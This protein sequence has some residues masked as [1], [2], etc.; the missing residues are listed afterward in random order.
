MKDEQV[1]TPEQERRIVQIIGE[2]V[3][4]LLRDVVGE[5]LRGD[6]QKPEPQRQ[7]TSQ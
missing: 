4:R 6:P 7:P 3:D 1:F 5:S 2:F